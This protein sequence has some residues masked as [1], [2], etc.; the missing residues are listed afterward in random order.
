MDL[1]EDDK[2][3]LVIDDHE[4]TLL[5]F[6]RV[7]SLKGLAVET[8]SGANPAI[9]WMEV[10]NRPD[11]IFCDIHMPDGNATV[12]INWLKEKDFS[13]PLVLISA[14]HFADFHSHPFLLKPLMQEDIYNILEQH[15]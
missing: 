15:L 8:F 12:L 14:D 13:I 7:I 6:S 5:L 10:N 4:A 9:A 1:R 2:V 11:L 3:I